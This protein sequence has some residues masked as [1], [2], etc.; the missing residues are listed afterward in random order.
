[1]WG[2]TGVA[3]SPPR[4]QWP[5]GV[6]I[7]SFTIHVLP[8]SAVTSHSTPGRRSETEPEP[9]GHQTRRPSPLPVT[10]LLFAV[11]LLCSKGGGPQLRYFKL[12]THCLPLP[13]FL[14]FPT[15]GTGMLPGSPMVV[16]RANRTA[17]L[18]TPL[19]VR[20]KRRGSL[21]ASRGGPGACTPVATT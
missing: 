7:S 13:L 15:S 8:L 17:T 12:K 3:R 2:W 4:G 19:F 20:A 14:L 10:C 1:M 6:G 18:I 5:T 16:T 11:C 21:C 9:T